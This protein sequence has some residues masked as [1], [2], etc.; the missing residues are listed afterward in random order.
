MSSRPT[1]LSVGSTASLRDWVAALSC[2]AVSLGPWVIRILNWLSGVLAIVFLIPTV[3]VAIV[4]P[5]R[6]WDS[7]AFGSW[8]RSI[9]ETGNLWEN[10][11]VLDLSRPLFYVP[12]GIAWRVFGDDIWIGRLLSVLFAA[13]LVLAVWVLGRA[14]T[15]DRATKALMPVLAL[16]TLLASAVFASYVAAGMT[17]VPVAAATALAGALL[18]SA[19]VAAPTARSSR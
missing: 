7:L 9:A 12:Q 3:F 5:Y 1:T 11:S 17:D 19:W 4:L 8:S 18:F 16:G 2:P 14:L 13:A 10:G 15:D 6:Y